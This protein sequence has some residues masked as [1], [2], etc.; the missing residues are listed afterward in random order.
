MRQRANNIRTQ[1]TEAG[2]QE[3]VLTLTGKQDISDLK[4]VI[5]RGKEL[6]V[7]IKQYR[8]RRSLDANAYLW[9]L[10]QKIAE[11]IGQTA[12]NVYRAFIRR[13]GQWEMLPIKSEAVDRWLEVWGGKGIGWFAEVAY[14]SKLE[15]YTTIKSYYG[16]SVYD[17]REMSIL[18][19][20][21]VTECKELGIET[22]TPAEI[23]S[24]K[25]QWEGG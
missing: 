10:C 8:N 12:D 14:T 9:V 11:S 4:S 25:S 5:E 6:T 21:I 22:M 15:G 23:E 20:E 2:K 17:T 16:S 19:D 7:E 13:V 24:L 1:F 3:I 18:I